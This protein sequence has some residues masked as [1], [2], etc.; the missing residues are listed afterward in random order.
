MRLASLETK[1]ETLAEKFSY[2]EIS[3][4]KTLKRFSPNPALTKEFKQVSETIVEDNQDY[5]IVVHQ[6]NLPKPGAGFK[7]VKEV[8]G[9]VIYYK[10]VPNKKTKYFKVYKKCS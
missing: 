1:L 2:L 8:N 6:I 4:P 5:D 7:T 9:L 10:K 3:Q